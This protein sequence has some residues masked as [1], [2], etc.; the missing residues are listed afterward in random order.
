MDQPYRRLQYR[1]ERSFAADQGA[2]DVEAL[3]GQEL[4]E[5]VAGDAARD[6]RVTLPDE[7]GVLVPEIPQLLVDLA[8]ASPFL[9][10]LLQILLA[11]EQGGF[12]DG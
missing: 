5:V 2:G 9:D 10:Y 12:N 6:V 11:G 4:V 7:V 3:L 1:G 8:T